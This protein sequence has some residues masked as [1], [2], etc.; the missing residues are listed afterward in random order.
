MLGLVGAVSAQGQRALRADRSTQPIGSSALAT[1]SVTGTFT[2][3]GQL[4]NGGSPVNGSCDLQFSLFDASSGPNQIG[5]TQSVNSQ[6]VSSGL[7]TVLLNNSGQF[8]ATPF[9]GEARWIEIAVRCPTSIGGFMTL[10]P[11]QQLTAA[12]YASSLMPGAV[13]S[14]SINPILTV[15]TTNGA[16][17]I[18]AIV[19]H[20]IITNPGGVSA[21]VRG[22]NDGTGNLGIGVFGSQNGSGWGVYGS[23]PSGA[24]VRAT[25]VSGNGVYANSSSGIG[26]YGASTSGPGVYG[27]SITAS[28]VQGSAPL[29]GVTGIATA[30]TGLGIYGVTEGTAGIGVFGNAPA[31]SGK[32][33]GIYGNS[34]SDLGIGVDG[35]NSSATGQ[36]IGMK[37]GVMS[38][39]GIGVYGSAPITG[40]MGSSTDQYGTGVFGVNENSTHGYG[41][42]GNSN[43]TQGIGVVG[44][45]ERNE[46]NVGSGVQGYSIGGFGVTGFSISGTAIAGLSTNNGSWL[47][48]PN[49]TGVYGYSNQGDGVLGRSNVAGKSG[50]YGSNTNN[51]G[52]GVYGTAPITGVTGIA[53]AT[54]G[55]GVYGNATALDGAGTGIY[56]TGGYVGVK[57]ESATNYH[58]VIGRNTGG[59]GASP[60][61]GAGVW[62]DSGTT[63][64]VYGLS[65]GIA[66]VVGTATR[67]SGYGVWAQ[68]NIV[69]GTALAITGGGIKVSGAGISTTTPVFIHIATSGNTS[70]NFTC[71]DNVMTNDDSTAILIIT[72]N[73][74][75]NNVYNAHP[76][77]VFY[78]APNWC[79]FNEDV[80]TNPPAT[81]P[82]GAAFNVMVIKP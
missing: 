64:G 62:G 24:G 55:I 32:S 6:S 60:L 53:T 11:R 58:G 81:M 31:T 13:I 54:N 2:Y 72:Q 12:P 42:F 28:G 22:I 40:V 79:I 17:S 75:P 70:F 56:G 61:P 46:L 3:Q 16:S 21:G 23:A 77:G 47:G 67:A 39:D 52:Y 33:V 68:N 34:A 10:N 80:S 50:V 9:N 43:G 25:S 63:Y 38:T 44:T 65:S 78:A 37:G 29:T 66:G 69:T 41:V 57:G 71:I 14:G 49:G 82:L 15:N 8:G 4:K 73:Y 30:T 1:T 7:F 76:V 5:S 18:A 74:S 19:G 35:Y 51:N 27:S 59:S 45:N 20:V 36:T 48:A 26:V